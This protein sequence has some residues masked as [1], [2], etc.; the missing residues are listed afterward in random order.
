MFSAGPRLVSARGTV[1]IPNVP[2][3]GKKRM[4]VRAS[5]TSIPLDPCGFATNTETEDYT[6]NITG[7]HV[8]VEEDI[9]KEVLVFPNPCRH[10]LTVSSD[11]FRKYDYSI[12]NTMGQILKNGR[13]DGQ[14]NYTID[15]EGI[16]PGTYILNWINGEERR[17]FRFVKH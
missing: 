14:R 15:T 4:R 2:F 10:Y 3:L 1:K 12:A 9:Q 8:G 11:H 6:I 17:Q 16:P 7:I 13:V 5:W